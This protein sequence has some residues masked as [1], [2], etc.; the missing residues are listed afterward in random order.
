MS[1]EGKR[2][3][4]DEAEDED[5]DV[6]GPSSTIQLSHQ[7]SLFLREM[8]YFTLRQCLNGLL[9]LFLA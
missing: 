8:S 7:L 4:E 3:D 1:L 9:V 6:F 2:T 5:N